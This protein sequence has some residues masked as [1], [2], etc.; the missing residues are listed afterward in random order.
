MCR[1]NSRKEETSL[2]GFSYPIFINLLKKSFFF[3]DDKTR[4]IKFHSPSWAK[5]RQ[6]FRTLSCVC[7]ILLFSPSFPEKTANLIYLWKKNDEKFPDEN[8]FLSIRQIS[9][10]AHH[11][12]VLC[13]AFCLHQ[14]HEKLI[15]Y[16]I[17]YEFFSLFR[18]HGAIFHTRRK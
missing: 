18:L 2:E 10:A 5:F 9:P 13:S 7:L 12:L 11:A 16:L 1:I 4:K 8:A 6:K 17:K 15:N 3:R 14:Q